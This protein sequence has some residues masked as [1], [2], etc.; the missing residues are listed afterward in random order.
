MT[1]FFLGN[2]MEHEIL[3]ADNHIRWVKSPNRRMKSG[4][5]LT[6]A[7]LPE[8]PLRQVTAHP[9]FVSHDPTRVLVDVL[10]TRDVS[11]ILVQPPD[12]INIHH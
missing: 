7:V 10:K 8:N 5:G 12:D 2:D 11:P 3:K 9:V 6:I 4:N 1:P